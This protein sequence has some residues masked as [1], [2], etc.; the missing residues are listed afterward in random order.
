MP[1]QRKVFRIEQMGPIGTPAAAFDDRTIP[2]ADRHEIVAE[3]K[4]LRALMERRAASAEPAD[5]I[6]D[7]GP[8]RDLHR[9]RQETDAIH[10]ALSRTKQEIAALHAGTGSVATPARASRELDAVAQGAEQA[11]QLILGAAEAIEDAA[12]SLAASLTRQQEAA[13]ALDIQDNV[14]RIFEACNFQDLAGQR[15]TKVMK[16]LQFVEQRIACMVEIWGGIDALRGDPSLAPAEG[17]PGTAM[18]G[19]KLNDD[20]GHA[21]QDEIDRMFATG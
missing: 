3:L 16:T 2:A 13:L 7:G 8:A 21:S 6:D 11:T 12:R 19:P 10:L 1:V 5:A 9:L 4:A 20:R 17:D 14:L 18:H 15:M